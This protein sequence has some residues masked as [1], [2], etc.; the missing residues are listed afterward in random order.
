MTSDLAV[1]NSHEAK[2]QLQNK[3]EQEINLQKIRIFSELENQM[4]FI[5]HLVLR[6]VYFVVFFPEKFSFIE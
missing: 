5:Y 1:A 2:M 3:Q 6:R 4:E